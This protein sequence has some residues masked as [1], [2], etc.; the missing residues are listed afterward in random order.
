LETIL[1]TIFQLPGALASR[2]D[3]LSMK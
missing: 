1:S 3:V 2:F